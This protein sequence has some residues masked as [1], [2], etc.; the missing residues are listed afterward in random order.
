[1]AVELPTVL[2]SCQRCLRT[3]GRKGSQ[4]QAM[5]GAHLPVAG[6]QLALTSGHCGPT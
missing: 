3:A 1:M 2:E 6:G 5:L 4:V